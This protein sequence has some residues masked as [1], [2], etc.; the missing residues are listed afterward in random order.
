MAEALFD[1]LKFLVL[2]ENS[3]ARRIK[4]KAYEAHGAV[5][6]SSATEATHV[7]V[8][9]AAQPP[10]TNKPILNS[11]WASDSI[12][13]GRLL[14]LDKYVAR[15]SSV[16]TFPSKKVK[17]DAD[18][19]KDDEVSEKR[20]E[21]KNERTTTNQAIL[22]TLF[23]LARTRKVF[24]NEQ[25]S[26]AYLRAAEKLMKHNAE[27]VDIDSAVSFFGKGKIARVAADIASGKGASYV[28]PDLQQEVD[29]LAEFESIYGIG[30]KK[31][32]QFYKMGCRT[33][34]DLKKHTEDKRM[35]VSIEHHNDFVARMSRYVVS[36]HFKVLKSTI[37][38]VD[39]DAQVFCMGSYR[40]GQTDCGDIDV[41]VTKPDSKKAEIAKIISDTI[42]ILEAKH[43]VKFTFSYEDTR[44]LGATALS[45]NRWRRMD[46][47]GVPWDELG[48]AF[49]YYT[50]NDYYN[51]RLRLRA[52]KMGMKLTDKGLFQRGDPPTLLE[53]HSE[54]RIF[55][56]LGE[57]WL[58]PT[59]RNIS[60]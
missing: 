10:D 43:F 24:G 13:A 35:L 8:D 7:L 16:E 3:K 37:L 42:K 18:S 58:E 33:L 29:T 26:R 45:D 11:A 20:T 30:P 60:P 14:P 22:K 15:K 44:W 31:A 52:T 49:I 40:R 4:C 25:S 36:E 19:N 1:N 28:S 48:A 59:E 21:L 46:I 32:L 39:A 5:I 17:L 51:R 56:L 38:K 53:G 41:I 23:E 34:E 57:P 47:L 54:K 55:S 12:E 50:G 6:V 9:N 27:I 2:P